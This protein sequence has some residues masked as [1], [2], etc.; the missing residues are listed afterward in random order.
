MTDDSIKQG[1]Q[2]VA[3]ELYEK[4]GKLTP[5][6]LVDAAKPKDSPAHDGFEWSDKKAGHEYRLWQARGW[7]RRIEIR[8]EPEA[9]PERPIN[10]PRIVQADDAQD[11]SREGEYQLPSVLIQRPDEFARA[12]EQAQGKF[13]AARR[14][15]DELYTAAE[16]TERTDQAAV[17]AQMAKAAE[18]WASALEAM[19]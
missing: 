6:A 1:V 5:S 16:R 9:A 3:Q 17:I 12:L 19:H 13:T 15:L 4:H 8:S 18:L 14:A 2:Q 7:F 10:V 11:D